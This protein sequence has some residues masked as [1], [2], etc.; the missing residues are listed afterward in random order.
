MDDRRLTIDDDD[1]AVACDTLTLF[2]LGQQRTTTS[3]SCRGTVVCTTTTT[4]HP[5]LWAATPAAHNNL[6]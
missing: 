1:D 5:A 4:I 3:S 6:L 2:D